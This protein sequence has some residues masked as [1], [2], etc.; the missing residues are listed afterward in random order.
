[1][2]VVLIVL[3]FLLM[4]AYAGNELTRK[5]LKVKTSEDYVSLPIRFYDQNVKFQYLV[6]SNKEMLFILIPT[7]KSK[8]EKDYFTSLT[9]SIRWFLKNYKVSKIPQK[10]ISFVLDGNT[11]DYQYAFVISKDNLRL[12]NRDF[13]S[14]D[15]VAFNDKG[16]LVYPIKLILRRGEFMGKGK[17]LKSI[18]KQYSKFLETFDISPLIEGAV[19]SW[20]K[21]KKTN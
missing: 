9:V 12:D 16:G 14:K 5:F 13:G 8:S 6:S 4:N 7:R 10:D 19:E 18:K 3:V 17:N 15:L 11:K 20:Y 21:K 1:M 2:R